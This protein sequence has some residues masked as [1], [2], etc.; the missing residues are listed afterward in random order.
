MNPRSDD[1]PWAEAVTSSRTVMVALLLGV[2]ALTAAAVAFAPLGVVLPQVA[3]PAA[4]AGLVAPAIGYRVYLGVRAVRP[5]ATSRRERAAAFRRATILSAA[6]TES[7][8]ML[9]I[10]A[11]V[12][13]A[14]WAA[15]TGVV[16][17]VILVGAVWPS[18]ERLESFV[19]DVASPPE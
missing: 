14:D 12:M 3:V 5:G 15:L 17:H 13:S 11:Y 6:V 7:A 16:T 4:L 2:V 18:R 9:G 19:A 8:A 10:I 1:D